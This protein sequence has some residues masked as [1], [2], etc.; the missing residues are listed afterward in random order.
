MIVMVFIY[1]VYLSVKC[2]V[3]DKDKSASK[4][5][6]P[7]TPASVIIL[8]RSGEDAVKKGFHFQPLGFYKVNKADAAGYHDLKNQASC[9]RINIHMTLDAAS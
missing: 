1:R 3:T 6:D 4:S 2:A 7:A 5:E 8:D 9:S